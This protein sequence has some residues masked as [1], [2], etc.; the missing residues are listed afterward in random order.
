MLPGWALWN[1]RGEYQSRQIFEGSAD[2]LYHRGIHSITE[3]AKAFL[4]SLAGATGWSWSL[5]GGGPD[6]DKE[7]GGIRT[8]AHHFG[9]NPAGHCFDEAHPEFTEVVKLFKIFCHSIYRK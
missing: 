1:L 6:P 7:N 5:I 3:V 2:L 9:A 4:T 8:V